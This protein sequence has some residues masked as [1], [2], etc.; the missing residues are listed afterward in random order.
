MLGEC[1]AASLIAWIICAVCRRADCGAL[2]P[3][4]H[5]DGGF[6]ALLLIALVWGPRSTP[7]SDR[8]RGQPARLSR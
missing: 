2:L 3:G 8:S 1:C 7:S 6:G 4:I 5:I